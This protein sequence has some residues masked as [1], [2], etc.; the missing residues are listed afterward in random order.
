[1]SDDNKKEGVEYVP[2]S[3]VV[4][5]HY[6]DLVEGKKDL[7]ASIAAAYGSDGLGIVAIKG[8]PGFVKARADLLPLAQR[9]GTLPA[10]VLAKLEHPQSHYNFGW[11]HGKENLQGKPDLAKGSFY[12]NPLHDA[13]YAHDPALVAKYPSFAS[14]NIWPT[15][16]LPELEPAFKAM[17][18]LMYETALVLSKELDKFVKARCPTY[19]DS[20]LHNILKSS[21]THKARLLHYFPQTPATDAK[22]EEAKT[23]EEKEAEI[24]TW[25]GWHN[26]HGSLTGL[27]PAM[28]IDEKGN[29]VPNPDPDAGLYIRSRQGKIIKATFPADHLA[30]QLGET[31]QIHSGGVLQATP[32]AVRGCSGLGKSKGVSRETMAFFLEPEWAEP[33]NVPE[34]VDPAAAVEGSGTR[35]LPKG[36][37]AL[38]SRWNPKQDFGAFTNDS[39]AA[40]DATGGAGMGAAGPAAAAATS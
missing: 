28:Y 5:L 15:E 9:L 23:E 34:G 29:E 14:A 35:Y 8:V 1:M 13:P 24:A 19:T 2:G 26:D 30:F 31:Q 22:P 39:L 7:S 11:S 37:P 20:K 36:V 27:V 25:C 6:E 21:K 32:H 12:A 40:Y 17:G 33:M 16:A 4:L 38:G 18:Q 3:P 10:D